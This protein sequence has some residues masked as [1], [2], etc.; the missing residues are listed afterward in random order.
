[1]KPDDRIFISYAIEDRD[2][3]IKLHSDLIAYGF[4]PW[5]AC[6]NLL[7]GQNREFAIKTTIEKCSYFIPLLSI[8]SVSKRGFVQKELK[9]GLEI[10]KTVP[11]SEP[12]IIPVRIDN[13]RPVD[14]ELRKIQWAD[15]FPSYEEGLKSILQALKNKS[16]PKIESAK[17]FNHN[18]NKTNNKINRNFRIVLSVAIS[19]VLTFFLFFIIPNDKPLSVQNDKPLSAPNDKPLSEIQ[20]IYNVKGTSKKEK[21]GNDQYIKTPD[22]PFNLE[23]TK[24]KKG[25]HLTWGY[26][27]NN[28]IIK[29]RIYRFPYDQKHEK[30]KPI[31]ETTDFQWTD[32][33]YRISFCEKYFYRVR[34]I[35][36]NEHMIKQI[37]SK[38]SVSVYEIYDAPQIALCYVAEEYLYVEWKAL[39]EKHHCSFKEYR[40]D[41]CTDYDMK[42]GKCTVWK[43]LFLRCGLEKVA[44]DECSIMLKNFKNAN[45][46]IMLINKDKQA[47][48]PAYFGIDSYGKCYKE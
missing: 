37:V 25:I 3:A 34:A 24:S 6:K 13:C 28:E 35:D 2:I 23:I 44:L 11:N 17:E 21:N 40:I 7:P 26:P 19:I 5:I 15:L 12:F 33:L 9:I 10:L 47:G 36:K 46:R 45:F 16:N 27:E 18:T 29:Y 4:K 20:P 8:N 31:D 41:R 32:N 42:S 22:P 14:D 30:H 38:K 1:M 43:S 39:P 48:K